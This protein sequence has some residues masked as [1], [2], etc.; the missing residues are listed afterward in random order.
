MM[1]SRVLVGVDGRPTGQDAIA[2]AR[3][4]T[5]PA[6]ELVLAHIRAGEPLPWRGSNPDFDAAQRSAA[7]ELLGRERDAAG[8]DAEL[9]IWP[10]STVGRGLHQLA[11]QRHSDLLTVGSC[12]H[13]FAGRVLMGDDT[14][15]ALNGASCA[16]AVAPVGYAH[17]LGTIKTIGVGY[18]GSPEAEAAVALAR[19]LAEQHGA[20]LRA[21]EVVRLPR[22]SYGFSAGML[23]GETLPGFVE[24][25][26]QR[27]S[28]LGDDIEGKAVLG[29]PGEELAAFGAQVDLLVVGSRSYGPVRRLML[30]STS[31]YLSRHARCP[32]LVLPRAAAAVG[33]E[34]PSDTAEAGAGPTIQAADASGAG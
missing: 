13:G 33:H 3:M 28:A 17:D 34:A 18:D 31:E 16:V 20:R 27:L 21:M 14:R 4:L 29:V 25:A 2:L 1:F 22:A 12:S 24:E 7:E 15:A 6:G 9:V 11:E 10:A 5:E 19:G 26:N 8:V 32:V 23:L 30:G